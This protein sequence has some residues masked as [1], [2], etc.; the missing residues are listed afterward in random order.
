[1]KIFLIFKEIKRLKFQLSIKLIT[2]LSYVLA[3]S[4]NQ[5]KFS[6]HASWNPNAIT[7]ADNTTIGINPFGIFVNTNN[8]VYVPDKANSRIQVWFNNSINPTRTIS[9]YLL[10]P[11]SLFV[12][13]SGDIYVDNADWYNQVSKRTLNTNSS[14]PAM[15]VGAACYSLFVDIKNTLYCSLHDLHQVVAQSLN[16]DSSITKIVAGTN[17]SGST[18]NLLHYPE[19]IF[20][21][22]NFDLYVADYK[23]NRIQ[24]FQSGKLNATTIAGSESP[25]TTITLSGPTGIVLDADG[26]LFIVE[27]NKNRIIGSG[28]DGFRCIAGCSGN[29]S[30][31][32]QLSSPQTLS[33]D[34][35]GNMFVTDWGNN[36]IQKFILL[37]NSSGKC[38]MVY[39][40][41]QSMNFG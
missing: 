1:L 37:T 41:E 15:Y 4:Y 21:D 31:S 18:S 40:K 16:N 10:H 29:G 26:Y 14:V 35:Y 17:Q 19:G 6:T 2:F 25:N 34:S 3:V 27:N 38:S 28:P 39:L 12:T 22:I 33:F 23:N 24:L 13:I 32:N 20:V 9:G 5:P 11:W 8:T 7:F 36:R 30:A